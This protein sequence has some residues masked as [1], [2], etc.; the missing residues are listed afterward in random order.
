MTAEKIKLSKWDTSEF[1][2]NENDISGYLVEAFADGDPV[3]IKSAMA[4]VAKARNM[5]DLAKKMGISRRG[6]YKMLSE[7]GNPEFVTVQKFL[8]AVGVQLTVIPCNDKSVSLQ[9][10]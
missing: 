1:L 4:D 8:N 5:T 10:A 6:L 9:E 7:D 3:I 2:E